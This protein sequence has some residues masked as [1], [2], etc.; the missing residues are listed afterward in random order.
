MNYY[1]PIIVPVLALALTL[2][3]LQGCSWIRSWGDV[4]LADIVGH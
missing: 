4:A 1:R 2:V 3:L